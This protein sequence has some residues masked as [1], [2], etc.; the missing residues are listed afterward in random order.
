MTVVKKNYL[1]KSLNDS[2]VYEGNCRS[3][4]LIATLGKIRRNTKRAELVKC[5]D[6]SDLYWKSQCGILKKSLE[7]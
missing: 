3:M 2:M 1:K 6:K 5:V 7:K 4:L